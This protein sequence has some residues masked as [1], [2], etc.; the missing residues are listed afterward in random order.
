MAY[1]IP[2]ENT[3]AISLADY[4]AFCDAQSDLLDRDAVMAGAGQLRALANN[5][6]FLARYLNEEMKVLHE[7][8]ARNSFKPPTFLLHRGRGYTVRAVAW[9]PLDEMSEPSMFSYFEA[10]DH[11][12]DFLTCG[13]HGP[14]YRTR[15]YSYEHEKV[16]GYPGEEVDLVF[17]EETT[18]PAGKT[19][20]YVAGRD[21]HIQYPPESLSISLNLILPRPGRP[22]LQYEIDVETRRIVAQFDDVRLRRSLIWA[23]K[24]AGDDNSDDLL[25]S[26]ARR[27]ACVRTRAFCWETLMCRRPELA[28]DYLRRAAGDPNAY[29]RSM[30]AQFHRQSNPAVRSSA[31]PRREASRDTQSSRFTTPA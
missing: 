3:N 27:H 12:F 29:V 17:S 16:A 5:R 18:L 24:Y 31:A 2:T 30:A 26:L 22:A 15:I 1:T 11:N 25:E 13:Y 21:V 28:D 10:H 6:T 9:L 4:V 8:Q 20:Y 23:L 19:M 7:F 14:G